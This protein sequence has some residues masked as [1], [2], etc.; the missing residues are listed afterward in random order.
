[1]LETAPPELASLFPTLAKKLQSQ[2]AC[3]QPLETGANF[4][5]RLRR[6]REVGRWA[7]G[8]PQVAIFASLL[9]CS[10]EARA[11]RRLYTR[12]DV[13]AAMACR[14]CPT[15]ELID[16]ALRSAHERLRERCAGVSVC[17]A[18]ALNVGN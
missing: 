4:S 9:L 17:A 13:P 5:S 2:L 3:F 14:R 16:L 12:A 18:G 10:A 6:A 11:R 1:M 8:G 7:W 15:D